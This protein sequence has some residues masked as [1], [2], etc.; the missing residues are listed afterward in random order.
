MHV[1][2]RMCFRGLRDRWLPLGEAASLAELMDTY[3]ENLDQESF[4]DLM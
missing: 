2:N 4:F 3:L 1:T